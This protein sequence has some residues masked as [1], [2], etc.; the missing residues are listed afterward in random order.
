[1]KSHLIHFDYRFVETYFFQFAK[2]MN[3]LEVLIFLQSVYL[4]V[5]LTWYFV[6][7]TNDSDVTLS[8][9]RIKVVHEPLLRLSH[10]LFVI[11]ELYIC[12]GIDLSIEQSLPV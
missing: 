4:N 8:S 6:F 5:Y 1:M 2:S 10:T 12:A 11:D 9:I 7:C 3:I